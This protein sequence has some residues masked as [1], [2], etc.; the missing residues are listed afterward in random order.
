MDLF[1]TKNN[2][3]IAMKQLADSR[4][5]EVALNYTTLSDFTK[6]IN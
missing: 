1:D 3:F 5:E 6:E 2:G 4:M